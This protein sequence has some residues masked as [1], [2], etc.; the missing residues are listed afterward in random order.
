VST[1]TYA[2]PSKIY[3][4]TCTAED[5]RKIRGRSAE[6]HRGSHTTKA[7]PWRTP[8]LVEFSL[9]TFSF[10]LHRGRSAEDARKIRGRPPRKSHHKSHTIEDT[11]SGGIQ[12]G[13]FSISPALRKIRGRSA[14]DLRGSHIREA[15][16]W[17]TPA[18]VEFGLTAFSIAST[19]SRRG[20]GIAK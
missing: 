14:E 10:H 8:A 9:S 7:T 6:D 11:S 3:H 13:N 15:T 12:F 4:F 18:L 16:L 1:N 17:R 2:T 19:A 20:P 5:P